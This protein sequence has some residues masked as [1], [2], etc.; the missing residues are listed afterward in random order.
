M[1]NDLIEASRLQATGRS[2]MMRRTRQVTESSFRTMKE[3]L[4]GK[5]CL[6]TGGAQGIGWAISMSLAR[7]GADVFACD[8]SESHLAR[9]AAF[10]QSWSGRITLD[11]CDVSD[12][13]AVTKWA[14]TAYARTRRFDVL[15]NNAIFTRWSTV[16]SS[17][18]EDSQATMRVGFEGMVL[19]TKAVLPRMLDAGSGHIV[20]IGSIMAKIVA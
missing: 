13:K 10:E 7:C 16:T 19:C 8:I 2:P 5:T 17:S 3:F 14:E 12:R 11:A 15:V 6:V 18:V 4:K 1:K 9:A 20:N